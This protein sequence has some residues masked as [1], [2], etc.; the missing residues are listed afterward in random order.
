[1]NHG[2]NWRPH[3]GLNLKSLTYSSTQSLT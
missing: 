2:T 3:P 1:M